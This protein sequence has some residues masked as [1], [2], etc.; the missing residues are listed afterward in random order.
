MLVPP[1]GSRKEFFLPHSSMKW[2]LSQPSRVLGMWDAFS[3]MFQLG[4]SLGDEKYMLDTWPHLMAR[5]VLTHEL[6]DH[7]MPVYEELKIAMDT[8]LAQGEAWETK[9]LLQTVRLIILQAGSRFTVGE[10]LCRDQVYLQHIMSTIDSIVAMAGATGF[11]PPFLRPILGPILCYPTYRK[12]RKL[13]SFYRDEFRHRLDLFGQGRDGEKVDLLQKMLRFARQKRP[14]ELATD[15]MTR[16]MCMANLAFIYLA[17]FTTTH[18]ITNI[19]A[20]NAEHDTIALLREEAESFASR[21]EDPRE[22]WTRRNTV[23]MV[24]AD[25]V[26]RE[27]LRLNTVP[28]RAVVRKVM[29]DGVVTD[30]GLPLPR[31][32]LV[33]FVS[34]PMHTDPDRF[35]DPLAFDPFRFV[36]IRQDEALSR[37]VNVQPGEVG[38]P[39]NPHS[40]LS[41]GGL[42]VF[43]RG[44]N[45]CPGRFLMDFQLKMMISHLV[46]NWDIAFP[47]SYGGKRLEA[48]WTLEFIFP[49]KHAQ[50]RVRRRLETQDEIKG[51]DSTEEEDGVLV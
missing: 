10:P 24:R 26:C 44:K 36:K 45:S 6:D 5:H 43:G 32:S 40:L 35:E 37:R 7:V 1:L 2:V 51:E 29:A 48:Q 16:R 17:S 4:H 20:S 28:T 34:H 22:L 50:F 18:I 27:S 8:H 47:E 49:A 14:E 46:C 33:S 23:E 3:E 31:G 9:N 15:Q 11:L 30:T 38:G 39:W 41:T 19:L 42:L 12:V 25:S 13:E 21:F